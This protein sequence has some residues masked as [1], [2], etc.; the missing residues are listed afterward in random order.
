MKPEQP[1]QKTF[2][3]TQD[4]VLYIAV[5]SIFLVRA[6]FLL[7]N[8]LLEGR[9]SFPPP[10]DDIT[11]FV[12][13]LR[14]LR[15]FNENGT[16]ELLH[17]FYSTPIHSPLSLLLGFVGFGLFGAR[18]FAPYLLNAVV[19]SICVASLIKLCRIE[20]GHGIIIAAIVS[21]LPFN[22]WAITFFHPD[23]LAGLITATF[24]TAL[25]TGRLSSYRSKTALLMGVF[26][27]IGILSKPTAFPVV[28]ALY[29][30][31]ALTILASYFLELKRNKSA[32]II[33]RT[34]L[35]NTVLLI[36][37]AIC[38][39]APY[40]LV[41]GKR[42]LAYIHMALVD[43]QV[44]AGVEGSFWHQATYYAINIDYFMG[45]SL[46]VLAICL[47]FLFA[48]NLS[49]K[50]GSVRII[51]SLIVI[52]VVAYTITSLP[53]VKLTI[54]GCYIYGIAIALLIVSLSGVVRWLELGSLKIANVILALMLLYVVYN[55][56]D[57]QY[58]PDRR[59]VA[60]ENS[61]YSEINAILLPRLV[62]VSVPAK[63]VPLVFFLYPWPVP[64]GAFTFNLLR[65]GVKLDDIANL[66]WATADI[67]KP[68]FDTY[69]RTFNR[70]NLIIIPSDE[71]VTE[72]AEHYPVNALVPELNRYL[73]ERTEFQ[74]IHTVETSYGQIYV[75]QRGE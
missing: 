21:F 74:L 49:K 1:L 59:L 35:F 7:T 8:S 13:A 62:N 72:M 25:L 18:E 2:T 10:Y 58:R 50:D 22:D 69:V 17:D 54:F 43:H 55:Y 53:K 15:L 12:D 41:N 45:V 70:A 73:R 32:F 23:L 20:L 19:I 30:T 36:A 68:D 40:F 57:I 26:A 60:A 56:K 61:Y 9:L 51:T 3:L 11:Y 5:L 46:F 34:A 44:V 39:I 67:I 37:A 47:V 29:G 14:R 6:G 24:C 48:L 31:T 4:N 63:P 27:G 33:N 42:L 66:N 75:Y 65:G 64:P 52:G 38:V 71:A 16:A 28:L